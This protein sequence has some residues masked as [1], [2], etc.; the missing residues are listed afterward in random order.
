MVSSQRMQT[1][2]QFSN[3]L[4]FSSLSLYNSSK[5]PLEFITVAVFIDCGSYIILF[6]TIFSL[7][8]ATVQYP[9]IGVVTSWSYEWHGGLRRTAGGRG[10]YFVQHESQCDVSENVYLP[11]CLGLSVNRIRSARLPKNNSPNLSDHH[12]T[13][14]T[15]TFA[16]PAPSQIPPLHCVH[17]T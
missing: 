15:M 5:S 16:P 4:S 8:E 17:N 7:I 11:Q 2:Q 3:S 12:R 1:F 9:L 13:P 10:N 6:Q 14:M